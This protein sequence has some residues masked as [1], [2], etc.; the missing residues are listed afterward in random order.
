[1]F[2]PFSSSR[3]RITTIDNFGIPVLK[4]IA[5]TVDTT[6]T[7][8]TYSIC[9]KL[10]KQLPCQGLFLLNVVNTPAGAANTYTVNLNGSC[11]QSQNSTSTVFTT[12]AKP[13][14]N[15]S[16]TQLTL[17]DISS[18]NRYL[19]Y[20]NKCDGTFQVVNYIVPATT[21]A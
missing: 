1:M 13:L 5:V 2:N 16:G 6:N 4:T 19:L 7:T 12:G 9:P 18:G 21:P 8:V 17:A 14:V 10:F 15:G 11:I 20:F 3:N